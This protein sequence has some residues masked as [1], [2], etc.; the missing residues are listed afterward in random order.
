MLRAMRSRPFRRTNPALS[1]LLKE[2]VL[3]KEAAGRAPATLECY[4]VRLGRLV[5]FLGDPQ[6]GAVSATDLAAG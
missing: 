5:A 3:A 6:I 4:R 2:Y 1:A